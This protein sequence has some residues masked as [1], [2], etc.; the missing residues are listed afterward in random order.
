MWGLLWGRGYILNMEL[1]A[2]QEAASRAGVTPKAIYY[3]I[4]RG[5]LTRH[6]QFG[7]VLVNLA[8]VERYKPRTALPGSPKRLVGYGILAGLSGG[9][10]SLIDRKA[11]E[12]E[13]ER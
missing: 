4:N 3:Q 7:R 13:L 12:K 1:V 8:E 5:E 10:Q 9:S 2:V 11:A 6:S